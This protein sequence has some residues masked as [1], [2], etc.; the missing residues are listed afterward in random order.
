MD[1]HRSK[2]P[3]KTRPMQNSHHATHWTDFLEAMRSEEDT[4]PHSTQDGDNSI[5]S[6]VA[7]ATRMTGRRSN[8]LEVSGRASGP[9]TGCTVINVERWRIIGTEEKLL[10][11]GLYRLLG[12]RSTALQAWYIGKSN[13]QD[14]WTTRFYKPHWAEVNLVSLQVSG[15]FVSKFCMQNRIVKLQVG[16]NQTFHI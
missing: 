1:Y 8:L 13:S 6:P 10:L 5:E 9:P 16:K 3:S 12:A 7:V 2:W 14:L 4:K 11:W 15:H